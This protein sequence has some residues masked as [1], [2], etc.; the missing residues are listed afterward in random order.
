[1]NMMIPAKRPRVRNSAG[2]TW[3]INYGDKLIGQNGYQTNELRTKYKGL[4]LIADYDKT[5]SVP[6]WVGRVFDHAVADYYDTAQEKYENGT[7]G[8]ASAK[9]FK[10]LAAVLVKI[11]D[12][13]RQP[14]AETPVKVH[15]KPELSEPSTSPGV[16]TIELEM[17]H[18]DSKAEAK[19]L[20]RYVEEVCGDR[21]AVR[22]ATYRP[23]RPVEED[24]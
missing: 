18:G 24:V 17:L 7:V 5:R 19:H 15:P 11:A 9:S 6:K 4:E 23:G 12:D 2:C 8:F 16:L 3:E 14:P 20:K 10:E 21:A 1:M 13:Y 22:R